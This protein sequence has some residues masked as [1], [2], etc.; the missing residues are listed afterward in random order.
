MG[1]FIING[2]KEVKERVY[3]GRVVPVGIGE[4]NYDVRRGR[5]I[6]EIT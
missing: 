5:K 1:V 2:V 6:E 3:S 4:I